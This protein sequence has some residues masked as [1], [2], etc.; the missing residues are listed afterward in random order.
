MLIQPR[1]EVRKVVVGPV[2]DVRHVAREAVDL[3][4]DRVREQHPDP[5]EDAEAGD[6]DQRDRHSPGHPALQEPDDGVED[7]GDHARGDQDQEH[8]AGG[9]RQRPQPEQRKR[10][11]DE[12]DPARDYDR[13]H[14]SARG[15]QVGRRGLERRVGA[16]AELRFVLRLIVRLRAGTLLRSP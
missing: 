12:L 9:P 5:G 2:D 4:A 10:Q 3:G 14:R 7:Q 16:L 11:E 8:G 15:W 1:L 6:V 13:R